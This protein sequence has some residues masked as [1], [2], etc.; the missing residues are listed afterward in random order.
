[1]NEPRPANH[2]DFDGA[3]RKMWATMAADRP[4]RVVG[5]MAGVAGVTIRSW[6]RKYQVPKVRNVGRRGRRDVATDA[7]RRG[8]AQRAQ[9]RED[10]IMARLDKMLASD[11]DAVAMSAIRTL[12]ERGWGTPYRSEQPAAQV[13]GDSL[14]EFVNAMR[15]GDAE[16]VGEPT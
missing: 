13:A 6:R 14:T 7:E 11:D 12:L 8:L 4:D 3:D 1:M 2:P 15:N 10:R 5:D 9:A 16:H